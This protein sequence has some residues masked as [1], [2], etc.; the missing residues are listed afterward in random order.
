MSMKLIKLGKTIT[1]I[2]SKGIIVNNDCSDELFQKVLH[3]VNQDDEESVRQ[4]LAPE[5]CA[6]EKKYEVKV[7]LINNIHS[8][9]NTYP[10]L[11]TI[12]DGALYRNGVNL[13]IPEEVAIKYVEAARDDKDLANSSKFMAIDNFWMWCSLNPNAQSRQ[14]L[15][16]FLAIHGM[17]IT[18]QGMFLAYRRVVTVNKVNKALIDFISNSYIKVKSVWKKN[19]K[20]YYVFEKP[21]GGYQLTTDEYLDDET[22]SLGTL[23]ECYLD[24]PNMAS[25]QFTDA[26][27]HTM[28]Y[29]IGVEARIPR[30][31]GNQSNQV[32]CSKGLHV[33]SKAYNYS[34]FGDTAI[35]VAVNPMDVL[36]V[37]VG[38]DG[39]LRT[40]AFTP[41]AVLTEEEENQILESG[42]YSAILFD[43]YSQQVENLQTMLDSS[44]PYELTVNNILNAV[45]YEQM[46]SIIIRLHAAERVLANRVKTI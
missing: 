28:D 15:F 34:G 24:L 12:M 36:A 41:V 8:L 19:P 14:D 42:D 35:V 13:S 39:K 3:L 11:F 44:T 46:D 32:S 31:E 2:T 43:H 20:H 6:E 18:E 29:R 40:C 9:A 25:S 30:H 38:E 22:E 10:G 37:P 45:S 4:L 21:F 7:N 26:H 23:E 1:V 16:T 33:A 5:L 27:T 17:P